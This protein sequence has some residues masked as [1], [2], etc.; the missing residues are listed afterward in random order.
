MD[1]GR[2]PRVQAE[3][4][5]RVGVKTVLE[6]LIIV[7][8]ILEIIKADSGLWFLLSLTYRWFLKVQN[9]VVVQILKL[10]GKKKV[11]SGT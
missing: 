4:M 6:F 7:I 8:V 9:F 2:H 1:Q 11:V 10:L 3:F 5:V